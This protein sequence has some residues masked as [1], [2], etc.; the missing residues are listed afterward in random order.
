MSIST[1]TR[2]CEGIEGDKRFVLPCAYARAYAHTW[3][4]LC[5]SRL[6]SLRSCPLVCNPWHSRALCCAVQGTVGR[7]AMRAGVA[8]EI[9]SGWDSQ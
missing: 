5:F 1:L 9:G 2:C 6:R 7:N 4:R 3:E 8:R